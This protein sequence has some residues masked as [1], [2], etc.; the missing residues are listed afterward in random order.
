MDITKVNEAWKTIHEA[1]RE[2]EQIVKE[3]LETEETIKANF[4]KPL[5][6]EGI[7]G[8]EHTFLKDELTI[9]LYFYYSDADGDYEY[10]IS[11]EQCKI[12]YYRPTESNA[13]TAQGMLDVKYDVH[14]IPISTGVREAV[15]TIYFKKYTK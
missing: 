7:K 11:C 12:V 8:F 10:A 15:Q 5:W 14:N 1:E 2:L 13:T 3:Y 4:I 9:K 6:K